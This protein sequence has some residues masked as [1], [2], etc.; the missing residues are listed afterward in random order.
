ML[1]ARAIT[2]AIARGDR[3]AFA[4]LY[5]AKFG[6]VYAAARRA[7]GRDESVCLD[8]AQEAFVR[9]IR[10]MKAIESEG[11]LD[12]WLVK[13]TTRAAYDWLRAER[14]R[15][16]RERRSLE[17]H[18]AVSEGAGSPSERLAWLRKELGTLDRAAADA[19]D[20]RVRAGMTLGQAG[21]ALGLSPGAVDGRV[22]RAVGR[23]RERAEE[24]FDG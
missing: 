4:L 13:T 1:D 15:L 19:I 22:S 8:I 24:E 2:A 12:G 11:A 16:A 18:A 3:D 7:T 9:A 20:M 10:K 17:G 23:L 21:R 5:S 14:R 6:L